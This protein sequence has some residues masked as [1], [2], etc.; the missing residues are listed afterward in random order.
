VAVA[1]VIVAAYA[2][3]NNG[4]NDQR[5]AEVNGEWNLVSTYKGS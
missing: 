4:S 1:V 3:M 5:E 2:L